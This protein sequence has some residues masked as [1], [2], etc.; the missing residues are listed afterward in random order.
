MKEVFYTQSE[1]VGY[2]MQ[3]QKRGLFALIHILANLLFRHTNPSGQFSV[4][5]VFFC[6]TSYSRSCNS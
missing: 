2:L 4:S 5:H 3:T 1:G 6:N